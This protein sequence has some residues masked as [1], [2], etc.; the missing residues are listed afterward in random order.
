M[1]NHENVALAQEVLYDLKFSR[2]AVVVPLRFRVTWIAALPRSRQM[3][4]CRPSDVPLSSFCRRSLLSA[5][6][7]KAVMQ[8]IFG[9]SLF[10]EIGSAYENSSSV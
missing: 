9:P 10:H 8:R 4:Q 3:C 5:M 6:D 7:P 2:P 1:A